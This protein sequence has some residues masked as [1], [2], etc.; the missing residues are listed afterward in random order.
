MDYFNSGIFMQQTKQEIKELVNIILKKSEMIKKDF[1]LQANATS[2]LKKLL[3]TKE[4]LTESKDKKCLLSDCRSK[5]DALDIRL[6]TE[7]KRISWQIK[8]LNEV[9]CTIKNKSEII[10]CFKF[11]KKNLNMQEKIQNALTALKEIQLDCEKSRK[12]FDDQII[13]LYREMNDISVGLSEEEKLRPISKVSSFFSCSKNKAKISAVTSS[14]IRLLSNEEEK[15]DEA[16]ETLSK[17]ALYDELNLK[18][19]TIYK[20]DQTMTN[21]ILF[22]PAIPEA[23]MSE[24]E[25]ET[26]HF[27]KDLDFSDIFSPRS[28]KKL[29]HYYEEIHK[30]GVTENNHDRMPKKNFS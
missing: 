10:N 24:D 19:S 27:E 6:E 26:T 11:K 8:T 3:K 7:T 18:L 21:S 29:I 15:L 22:L 30:K 20:S 5:V 2:D 9:I 28:V 17:E 4:K 23:S 14:S 13:R 25:K 12:N 1:K 16:K